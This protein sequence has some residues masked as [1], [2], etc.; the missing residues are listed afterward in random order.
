[1]LPMRAGKLALI[2]AAT[3]RT[4]KDECVILTY[5]EAGQDRHGS[6]VV[7]H[8]AGR[9]LRCD[10]ADAGGPEVRFTQHTPVKQARVRVPWGTVVT[11]KDKIRIT[12]R[13]NQKI[14]PLEFEVD[15]DPEVGEDC[16]LVKLRKIG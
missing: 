5:A 8:T 15:G 14:T 16:T 4:F 10:F 12:K 3:A 13:A 1:M 11:S 7:G 9:A 2:R 6:P